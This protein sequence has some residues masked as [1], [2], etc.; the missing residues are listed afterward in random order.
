MGTVSL[1]GQL[2]KP[3]GAIFI[4]VLGALSLAACATAPEPAPIIVAPPAPEPEVIIEPEPE[5]E[6]E[7]IDRR[8]T[9]PHMQGQRIVRAALLLPFSASSS[10]VRAEAASMLNA[11][12]LA[13]VERGGDSLLLIPKDTGGQEA[14]ARS[15]AQAA[16][17]E[18]ADII[19]G[20]LFAD[21]VRAVRDIAGP[22]GVPI[23]AFSTD[24]S[25]AGNGAF[26][27]SFP[28]D[29]EIDALIEYSRGQGADTLALLGPSDGLS[30]LYNRTLI[31]RGALA[32]ADIYPRFDA[33]ASTEAITR[34]SENKGLYGALMLT[35]TGDGLVELSPVLSFL[36]LDAEDVLTL[37]PSQW[38]EQDSL[39]GAPPLYGAVTVGP[40]QD[41]S[42]RFK[43]AYEA[44]IG[45]SPTRLASLAYDAVALAAFLDGER[46]NRALGRLY[47]RDGFA[48]V[49]GLFRFDADGVV[50]RSLSVYQLTSG[51]FIEIFPARTAFPPE[52]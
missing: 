47:N 18:G 11:A 35:A 22:Q 31:E 8:I 42:Q 41:S 40:D 1:R 37:G 3:F 27:L 15:A 39:R 21:S 52:S 20:P 19:L 51:G 28:P 29:L 14:G 9:P 16:L 17:E 46:G 10:A 34:L 33:D 30:R 23:I 24:R 13:M 50:E 7:I 48:G 25:A 26:L 38:L 5:P 32:S 44:A 43:A 49:D 6:P 2:E 4:S 12:Q 45:D 36:E